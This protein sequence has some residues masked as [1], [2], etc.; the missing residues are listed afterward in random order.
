MNGE[1]LEI[2]TITRTEIVLIKM[3]AGQYLNVNTGQGLS[4]GS[5][6]QFE[7]GKFIETSEG[8]NLGVW[9]SLFLRIP[10]REH[11]ALSSYYLGD[12]Y[13][14]KIATSL[15]PIVDIAEDVCRDKCNECE[16]LLK[17]A[18][19]SGINTYSLLNLLKVV[20]IYYARNA[21]HY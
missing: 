8:K 3:K 11:V 15:W 18:Q 1:V 2:G 20:S 16:K 19:N 21:C 13:H 5:S 14:H 7:V 10:R 17:A 12:Y 4:L 6:F 9:K